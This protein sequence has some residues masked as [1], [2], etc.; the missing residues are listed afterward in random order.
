MYPRL[1]ELLV[2]LLNAGQLTST[3]G[4]ENSTA[5]WK[6]FQAK[7]NRA[8]ANSQK[9]ADSWLLFAVCSMQSKSIL[10][11]LELR[12]LGRSGDASHWFY[13]AQRCANAVSQKKGGSFGNN[14][15]RIAM[16]VLAV[17]LWLSG[18][19]AATM[20]KQAGLRQVDHNSYTHEAEADRVLDLPGLGKPD[21][22]LFSG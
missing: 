21:F 11:L 15:A 1:A 8:V 2:L 5:V 7:I 9:A 3:Y 10:Q 13:T 19:R 22:G 20:P 12:D 17:A 16:A 18:L 4:S 6:R 14:M